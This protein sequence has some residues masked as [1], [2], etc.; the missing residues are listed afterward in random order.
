MPAVVLIDGNQME[1]RM[2]GESLGRWS[3][4]DVRAE[5]LVANAFSVALGTEEVTFLADDPIDFAYRGVEH[6][7]KTW[8]RYRSMT[9]PRRMVANSRSRKGTQASRIVDLRAAMEDNLIGAALTALPSQVETAQRVTLPGSRA[10]TDPGRPVESIEPQAVSD[11]VSDAAIEEGQLTPP[12]PSTFA[13]AMPSVRPE[14]VANDAEVETETDQPMIEA[15]A[16]PSPPTP[17]STPEMEADDQ[18]VT[19]SEADEDDRASRT[20]P[21]SVFKES[22][23]WA[24]AKGEPVGE[25][26]VDEPEAVPAE[27]AEELLQST[28]ASPGEPQE[29]KA[30]SDNAGMAETSDDPEAPAVAAT[31]E[32]EAVPAPW[33]DPT[34]LTEPEPEDLAAALYE[35]TSDIGSELESGPDEATPEALDAPIEPAPA[36]ASSDDSSTREP[37]PVPDAT[38]PKKEFVVDLGAFEDGDR[39]DS[40][41]RSSQREPEPAMAGAERSGIMGAV[42][43]AFVRG[44]GQHEHEFVEAPGGMGIVRHICAD[45]GHISIGVSE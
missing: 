5:R 39:D 42:R 37:D 43:A 38:T 25:A 32:D 11:T 40:S 30:A 45:C 44:K 14:P 7:A 23:P 6:M 20:R 29:A 2:E 18:E 15:D 33:I 28:E 19:L 41:D 4:V 9:L 24:K 34:A 16:A 21:D 31:E 17:E 12:V 22:V 26:M 27:S 3:L 8:A 1:L 13:P 10:T 35:D 36:L